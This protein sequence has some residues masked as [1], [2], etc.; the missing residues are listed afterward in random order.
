M[1]PEGDVDQA[2]PNDQNDNKSR[3][4]VLVSYTMQ[5]LLH[6]A[7]GFLEKLCMLWQKNMDD[8]DYI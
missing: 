3:L 8:D 2:S 5:Q 7:L 6:S 1:Y 4:V